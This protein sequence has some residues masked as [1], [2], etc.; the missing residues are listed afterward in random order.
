MKKSLTVSILP[1]LALGVSTLAAAGPADDVRCRETAFSQS[2]EHRDAEKFSSFIDAD[3]RFVG[4]SVQRGVEQI[5]AAWQ[6]FFA[7]DG[8]AIRWRPQF[9]EVLEEGRL[10]LTRGPYQLTSVDDSGNPIETWGTFNSVWRLHDNG[11]WKVVF[12]AGSPPN[13][14]PTE[15]QLVLL[16]SDNCNNSGESGD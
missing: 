13:Q 8:P 12:D 6:A 10:A 1:L 14:T 3:A 4:S 9:V 15:D 16:A 2:A 7:D 11:E 5:V